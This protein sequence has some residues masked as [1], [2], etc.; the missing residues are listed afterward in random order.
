MRRVVVGDTNR[1]R[2]EAKFTVGPLRCHGDSKF[3]F[4]VVGGLVVVFLYTYYN[5]SYRKH[6]EYHL[7]HQAHLHHLPYVQSWIQRWHLLP[8]QNLSWPLCLLG[9]L[10]RTPSKLYTDRAQQW[11]DSPVSRKLV[12]S[13]RQNH[14][15]FLTLT[16]FLFQPPKTLHSY[17]WLATASS[18]WP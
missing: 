5:V 18:T 12:S 14:S 8:L 10:R 9:E 11:V 17:S 6:L 2:S 4:S 15:F 16:T 3:K 1:T 13:H 7:L